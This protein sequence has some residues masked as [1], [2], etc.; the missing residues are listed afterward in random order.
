MGTNGRW[1]AAIGAG[2]V[3]MAVC[4]VVGDTVLPWDTATNVTT[5]ATAGVVIGAF[6]AV[7]AAAAIERSGAG[8]EG[9]GSSAPGT[10]GGGVRQRT[11][12]AGVQ[13]VQSG[14][15]KIRNQTINTIPAPLPPATP[16][17]PEPPESGVV[18]PK[19]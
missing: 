1:L 19:P 18:R 3:A 8:R 15:T 7:W 2:I 13:I 4:V 6:L 9:A 11:G 16:P 12:G 5:G 10:S 17:T 14:R